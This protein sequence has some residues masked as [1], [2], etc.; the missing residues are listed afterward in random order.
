MKHTAGRPSLV[1]TT[2][3]RGDARLDHRQRN[4][5]LG[6]VG[7][8]EDVP[9]PIERR[10]LITKT[11]KQSGKR[12]CESEG[13]VDPPKRLAVVR[14]RITEARRMLNALNARFPRG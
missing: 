1:V 4:R 8:S 14:E 6:P 2:L 3:Q 13:Y 10:H 12:R 5:H 9:N 7:D 11:P